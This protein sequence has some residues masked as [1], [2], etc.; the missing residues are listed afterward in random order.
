M[1]GW[2]SAPSICLKSVSLVVTGRLKDVLKRQ[3]LLE[4]SRHGGKALQ[5]L[6]SQPKINV[7]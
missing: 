7:D 3:N 4:L 2:L 1:D 6:M 5:V